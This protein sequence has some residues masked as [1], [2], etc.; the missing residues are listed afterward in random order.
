MN[1]PADAP[2]PG[3]PGQPSRSAAGL[4]ACGCLGLGAALAGC[5]Q[6]LCA[7]GTPAAEI[8]V[9]LSPEWPST[10]GLLTTVGCPANQECGF[11]TG[12]KTDAATPY[13]MIMTVLRPEAVDV[14]V[15]EEATG[16]QL[17][18][19]VLPVEYRP[20]GRQD[21]CGNGAAEAAVTVPYDPATPVV[22]RPDR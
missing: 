15:V 13:N 12:P 5:E 4:V 19:V 22:A 1:H 21:R 11:L 2:P 3:G 18:H 7:A 16:R 17:A 10:D 20:M 14:L 6:G 9:R 8:Y